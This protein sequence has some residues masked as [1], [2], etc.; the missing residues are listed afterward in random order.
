[1]TPALKMLALA[2]AFLP[3]T[4]AST[5]GDAGGRR[6]KLLRMQAILQE[7]LD[8]LEARNSIAELE[9]RLSEGSAAVMPPGPAVE[10]MDIDDGMPQPR[11]HA[12]ARIA[13]YSHGAAYAGTLMPY[14]LPTR[15]YGVTSY[16]VGLSWQAPTPS[17]AAVRLARVN[18]SKIA[19]RRKHR[20]GPGTPSDASLTSATADNT[21]APPAVANVSA[22]AA[23]PQNDA[24]APDA[25]AAQ[26]R[27]GRARHHMQRMARL[28]EAREGQNASGAVEEEPAAEAKVEAEVEAK[29]PP[30]EAKKP[31]AARRATSVPSTSMMS[32]ARTLL[33]FGTPVAVIVGVAV[34]FCLP[35][36]VVPSSTAASR[37]MRHTSAVDSADALGLLPLNM[38]MRGEL[39]SRVAARRCSNATALPI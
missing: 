32:W 23:A 18:A 15:T 3:I 10:L 29:T 13:S 33:M 34:G 17:K 36:D 2:A 26:H 31:A 24:A 16:L 30:T 9:G 25:A 6:E 7:E 27:R 12:S 8:D 38:S 11:A 21:S 28:R 35:I 1:M 19:L 14:P 39:R 4:A 37:S 20:V 22:T 5:G